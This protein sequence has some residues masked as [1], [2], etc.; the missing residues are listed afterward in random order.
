MK[1]LLYIG[2]ALFDDD[3]KIMDVCSLIKCGNRFK[4]ELSQKRVGTCPTRSD[5]PISDPNIQ[6][7]TPAYHIRPQRT[8]SDPD[9]I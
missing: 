2:I 9:H 3:E 5:P 4:W 7:E 6:Y 1:Y 8:I